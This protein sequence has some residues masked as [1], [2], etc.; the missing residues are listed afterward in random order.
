MEAI[1]DAAIVSRIRRQPV[2]ELVPRAARHGENATETR[3]HRE[4]WLFSVTL[5]LCGQWSLCLLWPMAPCLAGRVDV[6]HGLSGHERG[7]SAPKKIDRRRDR[8]SSIAACM[9]LRTS[10]LMSRTTSGS[11]AASGGYVASTWIG[12][13]NCVCHFDG[14]GN[15]T[16][17]GR[18]GHSVYRLKALQS[19]RPTIGKISALPTV[20]NGSSG[21]RLRSA[22]LTNS[23]RPN[24]PS[25]YARV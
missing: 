6:H 14:S 11:S 9:R 24:F 20:T 18:N 25:V 19:I 23:S 10:R 5:C 21:A 15:G 12:G 22:I 4:F 7:D 1:G 3:R 16:V 8:M 13:R 2:A 17:I